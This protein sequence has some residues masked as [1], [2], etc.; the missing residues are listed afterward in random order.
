[1]IKM[2]QTSDILNVKEDHPTTL[3]GPC[4]E[5]SGD[6]GD[7]HP[8]YFSLNIHDVTLHNAMLDSEALHNIVPK[9]I[10]EEFGLDITIVYNF[11]FPLT[12]KN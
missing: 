10:I 2:E 8:F 3:F 4:V 7:M 5:E 9:V 6:D 1:M 11:F 12:L